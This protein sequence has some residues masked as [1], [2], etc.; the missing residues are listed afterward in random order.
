MRYLGAI[1]I[2]L[3]L[4]GAAYAADTKPATSPATSTSQPA[5]PACCGDKCKAM[6]PT[7]CKSDAATGKTTCYMGGSCCVKN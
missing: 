5:L 2:V 3:G 7:C 4:L 6:G 1:L